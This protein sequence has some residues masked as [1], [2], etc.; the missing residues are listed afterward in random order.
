MAVEV[1]YGLAG[2]NNEMVRL[3][4]LKVEKSEL[5]KKLANFTYLPNF[6]V[7]VNYSQIRLPPSVV[8]DGGNDAVSFSLGLSIPLWFGKNRASVAEKTELINRSRFRKRAALQEVKGLVDK[9]YYNMTTARSI[10]ELYK[11]RFIPEAKDSMD[12]AEARYKT[13][14]ESLGRLLE[15]QSMWIDFRLLYYRAF[16]DYLKAIAELSRLTASELLK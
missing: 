13:G 15:T 12:F 1:M 3:A 8:K 10:A 4:G 14:K 7:G 9:V 6:S 5:E 16:T 2:K 11:K